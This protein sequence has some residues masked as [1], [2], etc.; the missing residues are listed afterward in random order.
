[1]LHWYE[2]LNQLGRVASEMEG[3][4]NYADCCRLQ[5]ALTLFGKLYLST[6]PPP[7]YIYL[8]KQKPK[9]NKQDSFPLSRQ[10]KDESESDCYS[11]CKSKETKLWF[12]RNSI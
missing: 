10:E 9:Q 2:T 6:S 7:L 5:L 11:R 4:A 8:K 3:R 12:K 1:M